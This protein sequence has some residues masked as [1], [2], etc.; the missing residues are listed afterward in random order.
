MK[1]KRLYTKKTRQRTERDDTIDP[2]WLLFVCCCCGSARTLMLRMSSLILFVRRVNVF[3]VLLSAKH[4][5]RIHFTCSAI[6]WFWC[7]F[8]FLLHFGQ[9]AAHE[10]IAMRSH[11][12]GFSVNPNWHICSFARRQ[13]FHFFW[14]PYPF[15]GSHWNS[16]KWYRQICAPIKMLLRVERGRV[17]TFTFKCHAFVSHAYSSFI[18]PF[19]C[20]FYVK[21]T[22]FAHKI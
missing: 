20:R 18:H 11:G 2:E 22:Y 1:K 13:R 10:R 8:F 6:F 9:V 16:L 7:C 15:P 19:A 4:Y 14:S 17:P 5:G 21:F 3:G 12:D